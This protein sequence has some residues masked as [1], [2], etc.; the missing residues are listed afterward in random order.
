MG[1]F[2][3]GDERLIAAPAPVLPDAPVDR[4]GRQVP[5][6]IPTIADRPARKAGQIVT[7]DDAYILA[8]TTEL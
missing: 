5:C 7:K 6:G 4:Q 3:D 8:T 1:S 2:H